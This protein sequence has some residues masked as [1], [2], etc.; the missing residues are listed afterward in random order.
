MCFLD[1]DFTVK[2]AKHVTIEELEA[3]LNKKEDFTF[4]KESELSAGALLAFMFVVRRVPLKKMHILREVLGFLWNSCTQVCKADFIFDSYIE[5]SIKE[6]KRQRRSAM[7]A[8]L[9]FVR[10][11]ET[12]SIPVQIERFWSCSENKEMLQI[13]AKCYFERKAFDA[14]HKSVLS[15]IVSDTDGAISG[16]EISRSE[17]FTREDLQMWPPI[18]KAVSNGVERVLVLSYDTDVVVL[19]LLLD[20]SWN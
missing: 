10:L 7:G 19:L 16:Q 14:E 3:H 9:Q 13:L 11:Q 18:H 12:T 8:P 20:K 17:S 5:N 6:G 2:P 4:K 1:G 15:G